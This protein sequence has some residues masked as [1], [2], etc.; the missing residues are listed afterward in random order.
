MS[1]KNE[2]VTSLIP[3]PGIAYFS[4]CQRVQ[5]MFWE[6][7]K[8]DDDG[9]ASGLPATVHYLYIYVPAGH[10]SKTKG[11]LPLFIRFSLWLFL[12]GDK[13]GSGWQD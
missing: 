11:C 1:S 3:V 12:S 10:R 8:G 7:G 9:K 13:Q 6:S 2:Y 4:S 5:E